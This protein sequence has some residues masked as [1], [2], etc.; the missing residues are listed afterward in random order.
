MPRPG[1][2]SAANRGKT[3]C[4]YLLCVF[5]GLLV[6]GRPAFLKADTLTLN[7][8]EVL[9][10]QIL[11]ETETQIVI[12]A[13]FYHGTIFSTRQVDKSDIRSI[14]HESMEQKQEK[15]AYASL[16]KYAPDPNQDLTKD[17]YAAGIA[18]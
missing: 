1:T 6:L 4:G 3:A 2:H 5:A 13:A 8:G 10:G 18:A 14:V 11:S 15:A 17:Q 7:S 9:E 16:A 12:E